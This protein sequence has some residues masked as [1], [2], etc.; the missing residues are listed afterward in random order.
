MPA[1]LHG[2]RVV[3]L[4]GIGPAPHAAMLLADLGADVVRVERPHGQTELIPQEADI[5][6]RGRRSVAADLKNP[7]DLRRVLRLVEKADVLIEGYRPGVAERL[8]IG[9]V[10][11]QALNPRLVYARMTGWGQ[12]GPLAQTAGHDINYLALTGALDAIGRAGEKP[13]APLNLVGDLG[14]GSLFA[15]TGILAALYGRERTGVGEVI[16]V[17]I[18]DGV[19]AL[20]AMIWALDQGGVWDGNRGTKLIDGGAPF[21]DTYAC[22]DGRYVAVGAVEPAFYAALLRGLGLEASELPEQH[23]R[24]SWPATRTLF[25]DRFRTRTRDEWTAAFDGVD[26]CVTPVLALNEVAQHPHLGARGTIVEAFG[27]H[28]AAPAPRFSGTPT[29]DLRAPRRAGQDDRTVFVEWGIDDRGTE[30]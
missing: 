2:L 3:E 11:C 5:V 6:Q 10:T 14:G 18:V 27:L 9:P 4:A 13:L 21:Y 15:V 28:Q 17:A 26:A 29:P 1:M 24:A 16:D 25:A 20:M 7:D 12:T 8:G 23:D 19:S 30:E 22:A